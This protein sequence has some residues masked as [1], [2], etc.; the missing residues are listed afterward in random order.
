MFTRRQSSA[1]RQ[2]HRDIVE[3]T[4]G[5]ELQ[6]H[7]TRKVNRK[8]HKDHKGKKKSKRQKVR[9]YEGNEGGTA[10]HQEFGHPPRTEGE[11]LTHEEDYCPLPGDYHATMRAEAGHHAK[12]A[13]D[14]K[15]T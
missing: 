10:R 12:A 13:K 15:G 14:A 7:K 6:K 3:E 9:E 11:G 5:K 8:E 1:W 4:Q 2:P